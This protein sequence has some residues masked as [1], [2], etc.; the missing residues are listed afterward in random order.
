MFYFSAIYNL[1]RLRHIII[2]IDVNGIYYAQV[3]EQARWALSAG[4]SAIENVFIIMSIVMVM[5]MMMMM[6]III[7]ITFTVYKIDRM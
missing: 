4:N 2:V 1:L 6:M 5:M 3:C 7:I